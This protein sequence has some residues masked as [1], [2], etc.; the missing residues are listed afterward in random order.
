MNTV[1]PRST[2]SNTTA[3]YN[4]TNMDISIL[5]VKKNESMQ[6]L[7]SETDSS[8]HCIIRMLPDFLLFCNE[9]MT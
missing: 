4:I 9:I 7:I 5:N 8:K 3:T 1:T 2:T 6:F